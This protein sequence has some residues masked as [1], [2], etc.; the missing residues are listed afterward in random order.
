MPPL[1][2]ARG[3]RSCLS[4][5][6]DA[7]IDMGSIKPATVN[8]H[9]VLSSSSM[10]THPPHDAVG[11]DNTVVLEAMH[12]ASAPPGSESSSSSHAAA[13]CSP[14][15]PPLPSSAPPCV[16]TSAASATDVAVAGNHI[17]LGVS[18]RYQHLSAAAAASVHD[19]CSSTGSA[20]DSAV[21]FTAAGHDIIPQCLK[22]PDPAPTGALHGVLVSTPALALMDRSRCSADSATAEQQHKGP[23]SRPQLELLLADL[24]HEAGLSQEQ[25]S[26][27][28]DACMHAGC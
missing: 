5:A 14:A 13:G 23:H 8:I 16:T 20:G 2:P 11:D 6:G 22:T 28:R 25:V 1:P 26:C 10:Q 21:Y 19:S 9:S 15:S 3:R 12:T 17:D 27:H 18:G 4:S 24:Q 7:H